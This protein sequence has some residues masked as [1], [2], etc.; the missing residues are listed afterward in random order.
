LKITTRTAD[1]PDRRAFDLP[2]GIAYL[3]AAAYGPLSRVTADAGRQALGARAAPW[4]LE[5]TA[6]VADVE[7]ARGEAATLINGRPED[8]ALVTS[9]SHAVAI[10]A[11]ALP[12][13]PGMRLLRMAGEHPS[14]VLSWA[15]LVNQGCTEEIVAEPKDG[16][17]TS[18]ML[19]AIERAGAPRLAV[20]TSSRYHWRDGAML[21][22]SV[23][24]PAVRRTGGALFV[25]ATHMV[26]VDPVDVRIIQPDFLAFPLFKWLMGP[27]GTA[28]L[29]VDP[30]RQNGQP[31]DRSATNC[32]LT[33]DFAW[34]GPAEGARRYDRGERDDPVSA[35]VAASAL[36]QMN[37]WGVENVA[38]HVKTLSDE[39]VARV[40]SAAVSL[41]VVAS[42]AP[43]ILGFRFDSSANAADIVSRLATQGVI[44]S[45]RGDIVRVSPHVYNDMSDV[46]H[47]ERALHRVIHELS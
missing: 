39:V 3:N 41:Q 24:A 36:S 10:A 11:A 38:A 42:R 13:E 46:D 1:L 32:R 22:L 2:P 45:A 17:W 16:N 35:A 33:P 19:E 23:I 31:T 4:S 34:A 27:Y 9:V 20:A 25:D 29:Y 7:R 28:F 12:V 21:D 15:T 37:S 30:K 8:L 43:H 47:F 18:A 14:N 6:A 26:G 44:V 40:T 5:S